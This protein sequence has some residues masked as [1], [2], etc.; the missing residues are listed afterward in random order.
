MSNAIKTSAQQNQAAAGAT[1]LSDMLNRL[2]NGRGPGSDAPQESFARWMTQHQNQAMPAAQAAAKPGAP[3]KQPQSAA[4]ATP[5]R[6]QSP[7]L[8][9]ANR[10][11]ASRQPTPP[12]AEAVAPESP[13]RPGD[14]KALRSKQEAARANR[15]AATDQKD[16]AD[17]ADGAAAARS[18]AKDPTR[19]PDEEDVRFKTASGEG[20][21][22][23]RELTPPPTVRPGDP[24]GMMAWLVSLTQADGAALQD[25][26]AEGA[27]TDV[28]PGADA[29]LDGDA[30]ATAGLGSGRA[31]GLAL[32][33]AAGG[34]GALS[35]QP[36]QSAQFGLKAGLDAGEGLGAA[37]LQVDA[38]LGRRDDASG[39]DAEALP[40][41]MAA[42]GARL[43]GLGQT[44]GQLTAARHETATLA[45]PLYAPDFAQKLA[46][47]VNLWVGQARSDG[48]MTAELHLNPAEMGPIN[49]KI[50]LDGNA[51]HVDFAAAAQETRQAIE[52]S[53]SMLSAALNEAGLSLS[54]GGVSSQTPQQQAFAQGFGPGQGGSAAR[55][56]SAPE[57]GADASDDAA[58]M[59]QVAPPRPGRA[60]GLDL[61]A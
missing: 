22:M 54:G 28:E 49:V 44:L 25:A 30:H 3:A 58:G 52:S 50:S 34:P 35:G 11:L 37:A 2:G 36:G 1:A 20:E 43:G 21:A 48:P 32:G 17:A 15:P 23:V 6:P 18:D 24:A 8:T 46:D 55:G 38:M 5:A 12:K 59:R 39:L 42:D 29:R 41:F 61:Y 27:L 13:Q 9:A 16:P 26:A 33:A 14:A 51:A 31:H 19:S 7:G 57:G 45:T 47:Q 53:L 56:A 60:G 10:A 4:P 40:G